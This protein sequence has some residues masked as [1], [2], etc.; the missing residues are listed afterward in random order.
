METF[1][2]DFLCHEEASLIQSQTE[3]YSERLLPTEE[4]QYLL[5]NAGITHNCISSV[6]ERHGCTVRIL[7]AY[8]LPYTASL[9]ILIQAAA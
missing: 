2:G 3:P 7:A 4:G 9:M 1:S 8:H 6:R 5:G